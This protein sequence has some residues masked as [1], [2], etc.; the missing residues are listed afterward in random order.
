[1]NAYIFQRIISIQRFKPFG[2]AQGMLLY[3]SITMVFSMGI[4]NLNAVFL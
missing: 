4:G 2:E 1:M 3:Y